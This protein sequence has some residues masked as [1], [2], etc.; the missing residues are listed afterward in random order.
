[1]R[2]SIFPLSQYVFMTWCLVKHW[3]KFYLSPSAY[4]SG[5]L[6]SSLAVNSDKSTGC[7]INIL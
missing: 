1:M 6:T 5:I 4:E 3:Y 2:G 7:G